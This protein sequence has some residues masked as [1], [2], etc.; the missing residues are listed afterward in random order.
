MYTL[1]GHSLD[2]NFGYKLS[3]ASSSNFSTCPKTATMTTTSGKTVSTGQAGRGG[4]DEGVFVGENV[5]E[6]YS[7]NFAA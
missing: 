2:L 3:G 7:L 4:T 5:E 6:K 1:L